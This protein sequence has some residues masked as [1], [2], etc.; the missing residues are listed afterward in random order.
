MTM[1]TDDLV[2][3]DEMEL[4]SEE[5]TYRLADGRI[6]RVS[7]GPD[8]DSNIQDD[9]SYGRLAWPVRTRSSEW[10][11]R[12]SRPEGFDGNAEILRGGQHDPIWWQPPVDIPRSSPEF[13][14]LRVALEDILSYGY[15]TLVLELL[16]GTDAYGRWIV[17]ES[18][19]LG[20]IEPFSELGPLIQNLW[21][22]LLDQ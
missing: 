10:T 12:T 2:E 7:L 15:A 20:G 6:V 4:P 19:A 21:G 1:T 11:G 3:L 17:R 8:Y 14:H 13:S 5:G 18:T 9:D 22:E 16:E